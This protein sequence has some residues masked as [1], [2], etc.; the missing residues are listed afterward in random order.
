VVGSFYVKDNA[1][2]YGNKLKKEG[3]NVKISYSDKT[4]FHY[5]YIKTYNNVDDAVFEVNPTREKTKFKD[6]WILAYSIDKGMTA[7]RSVTTNNT[8]SVSGAQTDTTMM[9]ETTLVSPDVMSSSSGNPSTLSADETKPNTLEAF[10]NDKNQY[11]FIFNTYNNVTKTKVN[12]KINVIDPDRL[13]LV[14]TV[15]SQDLI[16][17]NEPHNQSNSLEFIAE[18]FGYKKAQHGV[19]LKA[20]LS[21]QT[22]A[23]LSI[24]GDTLVVDF[25]LKRSEKGDV[26][27]MYNVFF[28]KDAAIMKPE[29]QFEVNSLVELLNEKGVYKIR[30]SGH[31]N[32]NA[33]GRIIEIDSAIPEYFSL[34]QAT[35]EKNGSAK[36]LSLKR[37]ELIQKYLINN[38]I[39]ED[40][41][42]I[43]GYGGKKPIYEKFDRLASKNV[44][45]EIEILQK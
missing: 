13:K 33:G 41:M 19:D 3:K 35:K 7:I 6:A 12:G 16:F 34:S 29:S 32:G 24:K 38:G 22:T 37:A 20:E 17:V 1:L 30:I 40:R 8:S 45:V 36:K 18:I 9:V 27:I 25:A 4:Q 5:V 15:M 2:K 28:F 43:V 23:F 26:L 31:T 39:S 42:E 10:I 14:R 21:E 11:K 44:R